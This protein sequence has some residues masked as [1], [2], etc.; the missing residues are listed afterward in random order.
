MGEAHP[1]VF[2]SLEEIYFSSTD[3]ASPRYKYENFM[4]SCIQVTQQPAEQSHSLTLLW[5]KIS[6]MNAP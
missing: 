2:H 4:P 3:Q 1:P 6:K 5:F